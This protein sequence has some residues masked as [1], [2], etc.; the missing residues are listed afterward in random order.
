MM[1]GSDVVRRVRAALFVARRL[2]LQPGVRRLSPHRAPNLGHTSAEQG[3][4]DGFRGDALTGWAWDIEQPTS[5]VAVDIYVDDVFVARTACDVSRADLTSAGLPDGRHGFAYRLPPSV[6]AT[7]GEVRVFAA[8]SG[9]E[10]PGGPVAVGG[11]GPEFS[12]TE[13]DRLAVR[14]WA[15][16]FAPAGGA[17]SMPL[18]HTA[19]GVRR[20]ILGGL[21]PA[22]P[23]A[24]L[25]V[26]GVMAYVNARF[27][28][29]DLPVHGLRAYVDLLRVAAE[30]FLDSPAGVPVGDDQLAALSRPTGWLLSGRIRAH[31]LLDLWMRETACAPPRTE[32]DAARGL[33]GFALDMLVRWR[34]PVELLGPSAIA[35]LREDAGDHGKTRF[36]AALAE[37]SDVRPL[38]VG[39]QVRSAG[40]AV[41]RLRLL[42]Q[43]LGLSQLGAVDT[44]SEA[45][46]TPPAPGVHIISAGARA[47]ALNLNARHSAEILTHL[48]MD[49]RL[50]T[51][52]PFGAREGAAS[53]DPTQPARA[54][55]LLHVQPDD[56]V[57]V[58]IR[59]PAS[60]LAGSRLI[61]FF[62]W[63]TE[64]VPAA[65]QLGLRLVDEIWTATTYS[66]ASLQ[67]ARPD[68]KVT[69][70]GHLV[71][72]RAKAASFQARRWAGAPEDATLF[73]FHFDAHSW[74]TRKNPV[75]IVR[76]FRLAF[77][78][79]E[80]VALLIKTRHREAGDD[81]KWAGWWSEL[82]EEAGE[83]A[84]I[85]IRN[86]NL[87]DAE[88]AALEA[89][90]DAFVSLHRS[91]GFGYGLAQAMLCGKPVIASAYSGNMDFMSEADS[92]LVATQRRPLHWREFLYASVDQ[93]WGEPDVA[94]AAKRMREVHADRAEAVRRGDRARDRILDQ[95]S[96]D[97]MARRYAAA[98]APAASTPGVADG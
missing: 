62:L 41:V 3:W 27:H 67:K 43:A 38:L 69:T 74:I 52:A 8:R 65:H 50:S 20:A 40:H 1:T 76:A 88:M 47:S 29:G 57:E 58:L 46:P 11:P 15:D 75:A 73:F 39:A 91:E 92:Y 48:A 36:E 13:A 90:C 24:G 97:T 84:R 25:P 93:V 49:F 4:L 89:G 9:L 30:R 55:T 70:V 21:D 12:A 14:A 35:F 71:L 81:L 64:I 7:G 16:R 98:L 53:L 54:V 19:Y 79:G 18:Q 87:D 80:K 31:P 34:L 28:G 6:R 68:V 17:V 45:A 56:A 10:L 86:D 78:A 5:R 59:T 66:A 51:V 26:S 33:C 72:D 42:A 32:A 61:G 22:W 37:R 95:C 63:E 60:Q 23:D 77:A 82:F 96:L 2:I 44:P 85:T 94:H 83:D